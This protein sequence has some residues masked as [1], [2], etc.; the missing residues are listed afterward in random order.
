MSSARA[1]TLAGLAVTQ[2]A[3]T[4]APSSAHST[5][6]LQGTHCNTNDLLLLHSTPAFGTPHPHRKRNCHSPSR[7]NSIFTILTTASHCS[8]HYCK[9]HSATNEYIA[10]VLQYLSSHPTITQ[11]CLL[12][13]L[14]TVQARQH[15]HLQQHKLLQDRHIHQV[16]QR[17]SH[18]HRSQL[19]H[20]LIQHKLALAALLA[21]LICCLI[22]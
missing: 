10:A 12:E 21:S 8:I 15:L 2:S 19:L 9:A 16:L 13:L 22:V 7:Q 6:L 17:C 11:V 3:F 1:A 20:A 4:T 18:F 14:L 5:T